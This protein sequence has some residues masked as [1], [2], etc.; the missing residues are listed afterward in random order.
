MMQKIEIAVVMTETI[1][2][3]AK[4]SYEISRADTSCVHCPACILILPYS[5]D[6][7]LSMHEN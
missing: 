1:Y 7:E 2:E 3:V 6:A 4:L 5:G